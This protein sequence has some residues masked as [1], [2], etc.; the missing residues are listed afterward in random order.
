MQ[1][2][3]CIL[4]TQS[5]MTQNTSIVTTYN[6]GTGGNIAYVNNSVAFY[7]AIQAINCYAYSGASFTFSGT[8]CYNTSYNDINYNSGDYTAYYC[9]Y[10]IQ[11][12]QAFQISAVTIL[13]D[14]ASFWQFNKCISFLLWFK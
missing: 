2:G 11:Y 13:M 14:P 12:P 10:N 6:D 7:Y 1:I 4:K 9:R 8:N 3:Q 5:N